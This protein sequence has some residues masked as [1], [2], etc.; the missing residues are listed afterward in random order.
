MCNAF[1]LEFCLFRMLERYHQFV[2]ADC[3]CFVCAKMNLTA[4]DA[5]QETSRAEVDDAS[6]D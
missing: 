1:C 2:A 4:V 3:F 6:G 5:K